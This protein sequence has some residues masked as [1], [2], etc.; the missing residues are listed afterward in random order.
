MNRGGNFNHL[1]YLS[2]ICY[3]IFSST[4]CYNLNYITVSFNYFVQ[5]NEVN[6]Y[7]FQ[8]GFLDRIRALVEILSPFS[9]HCVSN[10]RECLCLLNHFF[11]PSHWLIRASKWRAWKYPNLYYVFVVKTFLFVYQEV[12][13][14]SKSTKHLHEVHLPSLG[15][16]IK[17][18]W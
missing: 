17:T 8:M 2:I 15:V 6:I 10:L 16:T 5:R 13:Y 14:L 3:A 18:L 12:W 4:T 9:V 1:R 11:F 7:V